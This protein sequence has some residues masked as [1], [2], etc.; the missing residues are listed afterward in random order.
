M[1][2]ATCGEEE[3]ERDGGGGRPTLTSSGIM[4]TLSSKP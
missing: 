3:M 2:R 4:C 1:E